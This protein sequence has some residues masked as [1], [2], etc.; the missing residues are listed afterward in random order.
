M[1]RGLQQISRLEDLGDELPLLRDELGK[2]CINPAAAAWQ[3]TAG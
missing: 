1:S 2:R 3:R